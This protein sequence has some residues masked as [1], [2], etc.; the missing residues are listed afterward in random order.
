MPWAK[1]YMRPRED[2]SAGG[3]GVAPI[4]ARLR[5][6]T[7]SPVSGEESGLE[8]N[9][10]D[11]MV[12][13]R[14]REGWRRKR[15]TINSTDNNGASKRGQTADKEKNKKSW[16]H[17]RGRRRTSPAGPTETNLVSPG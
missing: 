14:R 5:Q 11:N 13:K 10:S 3:G 8:A 16:L 1:A 17:G 15:K 4:A 7:Y 2:T 12:A 9:E 6:R